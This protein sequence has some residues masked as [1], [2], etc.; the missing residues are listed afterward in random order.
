MG[1]GSWVLINGVMI[2]VTILISHIRGLITPL[3]TTHEPPSRG[4]LV[5]EAQ[6]TQR[7]QNPLTKGI[8]PKLG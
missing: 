7:L 1:G 2:R 3:L 8:Y 4:S 6:R 5:L